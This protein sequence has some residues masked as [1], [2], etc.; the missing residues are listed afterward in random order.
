MK[1]ISYGP[2]MISF[3]L[4]LRGFSSIRTNL[5]AA[6]LLISCVF[7]YKDKKFWTILFAVLSL[8][9]HKAT[10]FYFAFIIFY[11]IFRNRKISVIKIIGLVVIASLLAKGA[12]SYIINVIGTEGL[13]SSYVNYASNSLSGGGFFKNYW[14]MVVDQLALIV[15]C[16]FLYKYIIYDVNHNMDEHDK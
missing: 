14:K 13:D 16:G 5:S 10:I 1:S 15:A 7:M 6:L 11:Y 12:Q 3:Y 2:M 4:M 8:F 9:I